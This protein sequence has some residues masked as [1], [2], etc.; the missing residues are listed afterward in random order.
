MRGIHH[1]DL[2][3]TLSSF[4]ARIFASQGQQ[5][6]AVLA[7]KLAEG[8]ISREMGGQE[9]VY[10]LDDVLSELD[11]SRR[12]IITSEMRDRQVILTGTD[13]RDFAFADHVIRVKAGEFN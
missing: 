13:R 5:R 8:V 1:D 3:F 11:K 12:K 4:P 2:V 9:P 6:S 7:L 10:L